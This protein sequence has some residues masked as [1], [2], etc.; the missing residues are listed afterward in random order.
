MHSHIGMRFALTAHLNQ[1]GVKWEIASTHF[2]AQVRPNLCLF[3]RVYNTLLIRF[4]LVG[5]KRRCPTR[6]MPLVL[7]ALHLFPFYPCPCGLFLCVRTHVIHFICCCFSVQC[8]CMFCLKLWKQ[9]SLTKNTTLS[10]QYLVQVATFVFKHTAC[11][12]LY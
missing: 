11:Y 2:R 6:A 5:K 10:H 9:T 4:L 8:D 12:I 1:S 7:R 3:L